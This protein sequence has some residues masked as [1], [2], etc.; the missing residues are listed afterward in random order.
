MIP[1]QLWRQ[2]PP[3]PSPARDFGFGE[4]T[5]PDLVVGRKAPD[6][7]LPAAD[8]TTFRLSA[9]LGRRVVLF[10][11]PED[12]T[13]G[14]TIENLEFSALMPQFEVAGAMVVGISPD[15]VDAHCA[16]RDRHR[17][18]ATLVAD[19]DLKAIRAYG[20][21]GPKKTFGHSYD[22]VIRSSFLVDGRGRLAGVWKVTRI[23]GHAQ[24][25]LDAVLALPR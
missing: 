23:K 20:A 25:V 21:W 2:N 8:G 17:L 9:H 14:C 7:E 15:T 19:P 16:F 4:N 18:A 22:G 13:E 6:F 1:A 3:I 11:Y 10:F 24:S 5:L 12:G